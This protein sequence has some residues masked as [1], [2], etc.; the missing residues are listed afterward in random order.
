MEYTNRKI[1]VLI[2]LLTLF[3]SLSSSGQGDNV[4]VRIKEIR[5]E[6][7]RINKDITKF[8]VVQEDINDQ[9]AE[10]GILKKNYDGN[11][12]RKAVFTF[13]GETGQLTS[14]GYFL[15]GELIFVL[16]TEERYKS[17]IYMGKAETKSKEE[18][19]F[20]FRNEKLIRWIGNDG[21]IIDA[22]LY[23]EKEK[24]ILDDFKN[25]H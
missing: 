22:G 2:L 20:Y 11:T 17:P 3:S 14:E 21:K 25:I 16:E 5:K 12:L 18:N 1:I 4:E 15:N 6:C 19:R 7:D 8:K 10:G 13:F 23:Q 24:E 9:S